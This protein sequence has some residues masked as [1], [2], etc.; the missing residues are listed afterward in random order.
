MRDSVSSYG[1]VYQTTNMGDITLNSQGY[2]TIPEA[3]RPSGTVVAAL[4]AGWSTMYPLGAINI[5]SDGIYVMGAA[6]TNITN[7]RISYLIRP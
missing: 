2:Y 7:L 3:Q 4:I 1:V 6:N 5:T